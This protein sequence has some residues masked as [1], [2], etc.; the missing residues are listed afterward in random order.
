MYAPAPQRAG[1]DPWVE[2]AACRDT[3]PETFFPSAG[4]SGDHDPEAPAK[5]VCARCP[6]SRDCLREALRHEESTGIWGGLN[7]RERRELLR[8]A[9]S[10][11]AADPELDALLADDRLRLRPQQRERPA[12]V[13][14]LRHHG[15]GPRRI[16]GALGMTCRQVE[17]AWELAEFASSCTRG[18]TS[19]AERPPRPRGPRARVAGTDSGPAS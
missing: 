1:T 9:A 15:W 5:R 10:L 16:A 4:R 6:V 18:P 19:R 2:R 7:V 8:I 3:D 14:F 17:Q 13:W 11:G 12:Y